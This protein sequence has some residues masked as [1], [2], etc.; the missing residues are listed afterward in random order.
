MELWR[1]LIVASLLAWANLW[2][3]GILYQL[4]IWVSHELLKVQ[5]HRSLWQLPTQ[6]EATIIAAMLPV[7]VPLKSWWVASHFSTALCTVTLL[8]AMLSHRCL[9]YTCPSIMVQISELHYSCLCN[10]WLHFNLRAGVKEFEFNQSFNSIQREFLK[11][12]P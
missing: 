6:K 1:L 4:D 3:R 8:P 12:A 9:W 7:A 5:V 10:R 11:L 2:K